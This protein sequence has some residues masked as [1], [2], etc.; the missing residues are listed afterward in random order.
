MVSI[1]VPIYNCDSH[2]ARCIDSILNQTFTDWECLL[3]DDG[4]TDGSGVLCDEYAQ[5]DTRIK[6]FHKT[7][8][9][10]SSARNVGLEHAR[11]RWIGFVDSDDEVAKDFIFDFLQE[12]NDHDELIVQGFVIKKQD[13]ATSIVNFQ[14]GIK[15]VSEGLDILCRNHFPGTVWN[16]LFRSDILKSHGIKFNDVYKFKEDELFLLCYLKYINFI[17]FVCSYNYQYEEPDWN[18]KYVLGDVEVLKDCYSLV[19]RCILDTTRFTLLYHFN[20]YVD[21]V[22]GKILNR[23]PN[24]LLFEDVYYKIKY[25][26]NGITNKTA[27]W[28]CRL[29]LPVAKAVLSVVG[30]LKNIQ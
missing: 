23:D 25:Y 21:A 11:G 8:G 13:S 12:E 30:L 28:V 20:P 10:V 17:R 3:I 27:K 19:E 2:L 5:I 7:N 24:W 29:P 6:V 18:E 15:N 4:S 16:K 14:K 26:Q 22:I 9:G 1:I